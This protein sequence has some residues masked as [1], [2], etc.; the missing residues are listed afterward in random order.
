M[1][2]VYA[3]QRGDGSRV[4]VKLMQDSDARGETRRRLMREAKALTAIDCPYVVRVI[5][6]DAGSASDAPF[7]VMELLQGTD[8][9]HIVRK[10]GALDPAPTARL[11][12]R[13]C[14]GLA[15]AHRLGL[16]H[17]DV[18]PANIFVHELPT[19]ELVPKVCDFGIAKRSF[20]ACGR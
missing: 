9:D 20:G 14:R 12:E 5:D 10:W 13:A 6:V 4:A 1:A 19:G 17:R 11:F 15:V 18:K 16:I 8:L 7:I 3:A 2:V